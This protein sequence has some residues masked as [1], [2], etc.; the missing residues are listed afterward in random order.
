MLAA[1][2]SMLTQKD[3]WARAEHLMMLDRSSAVERLLKFMTPAQKTLAVAR[4]AASR[5]DANAK[6]QLDARSSPAE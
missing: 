2:G 5:N 3:H 6:K 1:L 4:N